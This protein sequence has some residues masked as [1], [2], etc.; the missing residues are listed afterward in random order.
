MDTAECTC[1]CLLKQYAV[2]GVTAGVLT[3]LFAVFQKQVRAPVIGNLNGVNNL[4][5][6]IQYVDYFQKRFF[7]S[8]VWVYVSGIVMFVE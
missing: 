7:S 6:R 8:K 3:M 4:H 2:H 5:F 1:N